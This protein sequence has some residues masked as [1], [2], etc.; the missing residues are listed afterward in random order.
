[1][2][3]R[4]Y[5]LPND[6]VPQRY[7]VDLDVSLDADAYQGRVAVTLDLR[8]ARSTVELHSRDLHLDTVHLTA[9]D[10]TWP[11]QV[12]L[13]P[14]REIAVLDFG[15]A[16]L[17]A[18]PA[19]L[20]IAFHGEIS[21][22]LEGLYRATDGPEQMLC[23]QCEETAAR[24][25]FPCWDEPAFKAVFAWRITTDPGPTVLANGPLVETV[26]GSDG[27][28]TWVFAPTAPMSSYLVAC[29]IGDI[30]ALPATVV[31]GTPLR[32]WTMRGKEHLGAFA[33]RYTAR[34]LPWFED[35]FAQ[36][37]HF[38]K[39]DQV[40]VPGFA[41]G[42][43]ENSGLVLFRQRLL[44]VNPDRTAWSQ[45]KIVALVIAHEFAHMWF[46]NLVTMQWWDDIWLNEAFAEWMAYHV[47][48]TLN[49]DYEMWEEFQLDKE[50]A[51]TLDGLATTH[52]IYSPVET[53]AQASE[54][55]DS[56]TYVKGCAVLRMLA[57]FLGDA[58]RAGLRTYIAE[59]AE[60][61]ARGA[62]LWRNLQQA[63]HQ[64]VT[65]I[66]ERWIRQPGHPVVHVTLETD[67]AATR[68]HCRQE[69]FLAGPGAAPPGEL[70]PVPLEIRYADT[71]G[72]HTLRTLLTEAEAVVPLPAQGA[73]AWC[74]ANADQVGFY[75]L[76]PDPA[77]L[78]RLLAHTSE[79]TPAEQMGLL[80]DQW[81]LL[82]NG[83][84]TM[85]RFLD[86]LAHLAHSENHHVLAL[87]VVN[88]RRLAAQLEHNGD[89]AALALFRAWV[90]ATFRGHLDRLGV[91]PTG[92]EPP[93]RAA[94][95][96]TVVEALALIAQDPAVL[97]ALAPWAERELGAP[98]TVDP[99]LAPSLLAAYAQFGDRPRLDHY[100]AV[101]EQRRV[102][103]APPEELER[104]CPMRRTRRGPTWRRAGTNCSAWA[105]RGRR[106]W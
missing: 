23:T 85:A 43:M 12:S 57:E 83:T 18:G 79:L 13:D 106:P 50:G 74:Y 58:F 87:V 97:A 5:R 77:L 54:L 72:T 56:I 2:N 46:G 35:Y 28:R 73:V 6:V 63:S 33:Q 102:V 64:P 16:D 90:A 9:G 24:S 34:L 40:A 65:E 89:A 26:T 98:G 105:V 76:D 88:L 15:A 59:F 1:M 104:P 70:W 41:A 19:R 75:R 29:A 100:A 51:L 96:A 11:G 69:R 21:R 92:E 27:R 84:Q 55:F 17:P 60:R 3:P 38:A 44:L 20:E 86:V 93:Q 68:L 101:Y 48:H 22:G 62:D 30:A 47:V 36:P 14:E 45:E 82:Q 10:R 91:A 53:A 94:A 49:P 37:Y 71:T 25:I 67:S 103:G 95:R 66:M 52:S 39:Y 80:S 8:A 32:I 4:A 61:N 42:A 7:D 81:A 99:N 78:D 31:N